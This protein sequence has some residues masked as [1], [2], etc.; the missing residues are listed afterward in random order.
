MT[1]VVTSMSNVGPA[2]GTVEFTGYFA[3]FNAPSKVVLILDM[4]LG[5][6]EIIP[7]LVLFSKNA[8]SFR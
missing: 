7:I 3:G 2:F 5:R 1:S 6:L 8:I 4:L